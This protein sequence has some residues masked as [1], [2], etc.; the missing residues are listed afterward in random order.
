MITAI[1]DVAD[2]LSNGA[3]GGSLEGRTH[4]MPAMVGYLNHWATAALCKERHFMKLL[5]NAARR[6][7][8][9]WS[10]QSYQSH[11]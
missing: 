7:Q 3:A 1:I 10:T 9:L 5:K 6:I 2:G 11:G 4:D 8:N